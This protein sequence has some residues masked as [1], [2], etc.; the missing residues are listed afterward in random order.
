[1]RRIFAGLATAA[2]LACPAAASAQRA[3]QSP[4]TFSE[5]AYPNLLDSR[6]FTM[7]GSG[8]SLFTVQGSPYRYLTRAHAGSPSSPQSF[9][10]AT[11]LGQ[12]QPL[13]AMDAN[14][15]AIAWNGQ[16]SGYRSPGGIFDNAQVTGGWNLIDVAMAPTGEA[17]GL[18]SGSTGL[19]VAFRPAGAASTFDIAGGQ[20]LP[21]AA[22]DDRVTGVGVAIDPDGGAAAVYQTYKSS[23]GSKVLVQS[24]RPRA[25]AG[26]LRP[27]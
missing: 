3:W 13:Y 6:G 2:I 5:S 23:G 4:Q 22:G 16:W 7:D 14:G 9:P 26:A 11:G 20:D 1:M 15:N 18:F 17:F 10:N 8:N 24:V 21:P 19:T 25:A 12:T 27:P